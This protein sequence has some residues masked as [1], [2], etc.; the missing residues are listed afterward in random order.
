VTGFGQFDR[1]LEGPL[2]LLSA[3]RRYLIRAFLLFASVWMVTTAIPLYRLSLWNHPTANWFS[4]SVATHLLRASEWYMLPHG[5]TIIALGPWD[6]FVVV[7]EIGAV[8][9]LV[10]VI[11]YV[12]LLA[13]LHGWRGLKGTTR[14]TIIWLAPLALGLFTAGM[15]TALLVLPWLYGFAYQIQGPAGISGTVS[16]TSFVTETLFFVLAMGLS[17]E[18]PV[19]TYGLG[20]VG[21]LKAP[22]MRR[23]MW[24]AFFACAGLALII[25]PGVGGGVIEVPMAMGLFGLYLVGYLMVKRAERSRATTGSAQEVLLG[26]SD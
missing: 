8:I 3:A 2:R 24:P 14:W 25:S 19:V 11:P 18:I 1:L 16:L 4:Y 5:E 22:A 9:A 15:V 13:L 26:E 7:C 23:A 6:T 12:T 20:Y 21:V 10:A 17:F